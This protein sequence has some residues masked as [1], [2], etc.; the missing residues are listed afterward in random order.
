MNI[1]ETLKN[2]KE[3]IINHITELI[4]NTVKAKAYYKKG[5]WELV[6]KNISDAYLNF[7][8]GLT[9]VSIA[10]KLQ[11]M[12]IKNDYIVKNLFDDVIKRVNK[13]YQ[14]NIVTKTIHNECH[15]IVIL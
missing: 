3:E 7:N 10:M 5:G 14:Y 15:S 6:H 12:G 1:I 13:H 4:I 11:D 2:D 8:F 9:N